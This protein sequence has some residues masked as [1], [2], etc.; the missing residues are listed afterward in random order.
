MRL[1][2]ITERPFTSCSMRPVDKQ[3][4]VANTRKRR[5]TGTLTADESGKSSSSYYCHK[6][7]Q[8][9]G[10]TKIDRNRPKSLHC[11][12]CRNE[13]KFG[14]AELLDLRNNWISS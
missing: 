11:G 14:A 10:F 12:N 9:C 6:I 2:P 7:L 5:S 3:A 8:N 13:A 4:R 1:T